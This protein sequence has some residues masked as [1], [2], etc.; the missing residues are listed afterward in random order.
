MKQGVYEESLLAKYPIGL[1]YKEPGPW[2]RVFHYSKAAAALDLPGWAHCD[3]NGQREQN[4]SVEARVVGDRDITIAL[5]GATKDQFRNGVIIV[6]VAPAGYERL[7]RIKTNDASVGANC[8]IYLKDPIN[9]AVPMPQFVCVYPCIYSLVDKVGLTSVGY[10]T[11]VVVPIIQVQNGYHFWGQTW[12]LAEFTGTRVPGGTHGE[13]DLYVNPAD[14]SFV[15]H[16]DILSEG[17]HTAV[18][19][20]WQRAG[21]LLPMTGA[22]AT[23]TLMMLQ[24]AP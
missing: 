16:E 14:G 2:S 12:G 9:V 20:S 18:N 11:A 7:Y 10:E 13:R 19:E 21:Y 23:D 8:K 22:L 3:T 24:L 4:T 5:A 15:L 17:A 6:H 1:R